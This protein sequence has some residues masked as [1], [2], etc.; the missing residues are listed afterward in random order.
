MS[1]TSGTG[2]GALRHLGQLRERGRVA[3]GEVGEQLAVHVHA[4]LLEAG[5]ERAVGEAVQAGGGVDAHDPQPPEVAL[6]EP[7]VLV[8]ELARALLGLECGLEQLAAA[9]VAAL[10]GLEDLLAAGTAGDDGLGAGHRTILLPARPPGA[11]GT[12]MPDRKAGSAPE[13]AAHA[14][15]VGLGHHHVRAFLAL[16]VAVVG[17]H[18]MSQMRR[19]PDRLAG[20]GELEALPRG[21]IGLHLGHLGS[22]PSRLT[23]PAAALPPGC[24]CWARAWPRSSPAAPWARARA[25]RCAPRRVA[26]APP[27]RDQRGRAGPAR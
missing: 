23:S 19:A 1:W 17:D 3:H 25:T 26:A 22:S 21:A 24:S 20:S 14:R 16:R 2:S 18:A 15:L 11:R 9:A 5:D 27:P 10:R 7:A 12:G 13:H 8:G 4:R 6:L